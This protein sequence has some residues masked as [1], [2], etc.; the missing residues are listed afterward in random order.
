VLNRNADESAQ[1]RKAI[2]GLLHSAG[3]VE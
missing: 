3:C 2:F 1:L